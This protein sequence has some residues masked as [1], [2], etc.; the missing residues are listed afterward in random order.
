MPWFKVSHN[1]YR[2]ISSEKE[3]E[4]LSQPKEQF[5]HVQ[6]DTMDP[7]WHP[8]TG[9]LVDSKARFRRLTKEAGCIEFGNENLSPKLEE[10]KDDSRAIGKMIWDQME[11]QHIDYRDLRRDI[12]ETFE[13]ARKYGRR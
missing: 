2:W 9:E 11:A 8:V 10:P 12:R 1:R 7:T 3:A 4:R 13:H 6:D 5:Y